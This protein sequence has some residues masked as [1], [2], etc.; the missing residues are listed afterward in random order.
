[1]DTPYYTQPDEDGRFRIGDVPDGE[2]TAVVWHEAAGSDSTRVVV[3]SG[4]DARV[5]FTLGG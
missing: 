1:V 3:T 4:G 2:Y 5:D